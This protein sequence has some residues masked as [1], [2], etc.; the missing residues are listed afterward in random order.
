MAE[1]VGSHW[2]HLRGVAVEVGF[3]F[4][5]VYRGPGEQEDPM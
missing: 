3:D 1:E 5:A 2:W 4:S